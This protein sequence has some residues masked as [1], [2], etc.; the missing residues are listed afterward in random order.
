MR[1][2]RKSCFNT[3]AGST[4]F[5]E[6]ASQVTDAQRQQCQRRLDELIQMTQADLTEDT[7]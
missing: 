1:A 4:V 2:S 5:T 7:L 6:N 3:D